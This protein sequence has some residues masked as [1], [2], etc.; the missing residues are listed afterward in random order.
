EA[1]PRLGWPIN[2]GSWT[3]FRNRPLELVADVEQGTRRRGEAMRALLD[4][5]PRDA[6]CMGFVSP[7]RIQHRL[8][9]DVHPGHPRY[10]EV[11][12]GDVAERVRD[13][14]RLLDRE[15]AALLKRTDPDDL[16]M[17]MS[18]HGHQPCTRA[19]NMNRVLE[20]LGL[21]RMGRGSGLVSL[22]AWGRLRSIARRIYDRLGLH[23]RVAVPTPPI[24]W[25]PTR[26]YTTLASTREGGAIAPAGG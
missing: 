21:L 3:T 24:D 20:Q 11:K 18:D 16:V 9:E 4:E 26:A 12:D 14:Y 7:D 23:G 13:V 10:P 8:L 5:Q 2:G 15:L 17:L 25:A 1:G 19:L 6:A 22:L